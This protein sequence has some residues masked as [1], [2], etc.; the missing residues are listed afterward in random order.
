M[1]RSIFLI[2]IF[3]GLTRV[4]H[5]SNY[6]VVLCI[7]NLTASSRNTNSII[8]L[9]LLCYIFGIGRLQSCVITRLLIPLPFFSS[10]FKTSV[11][12]NIKINGVF[13]FF[14]GPKEEDE[15]KQTGGGNVFPV[16]PR[17]KSRRHEDFDEVLSNSYLLQILESHRLQLLRLC[18]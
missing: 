10:E 6:H 1:S 18:S 8:V 16:W 7:Y 2:S 5:Q 11:G 12:R 3:L 9:S 4:H 13:L 15:S 14:G 17:C